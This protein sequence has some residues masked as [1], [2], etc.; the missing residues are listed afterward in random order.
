MSEV[1]LKQVQHDSPTIFIAMTNKKAPSENQKGLFIKSCSDYF[2]TNFV[3]VT[4]FL[5]TKEIV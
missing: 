2:T 4:L 1:I 5:V 3:V